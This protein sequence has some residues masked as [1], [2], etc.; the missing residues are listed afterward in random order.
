MLAEDCAAALEYMEKQIIRHTYNYQHAELQGAPD[1][2]LHNIKRKIGYYNV[3]VLAIKEA[4]GHD[5]H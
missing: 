1:E 5:E 2:M 4:T 3:A